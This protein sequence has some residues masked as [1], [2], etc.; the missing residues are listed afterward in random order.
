MTEFI[1]PFGLDHFIYL[2]IFLIIAGLFF[3]KRNKVTENKN[4]ITK[5]ILLT[6]ILQQ[7]VLYGSYFILEDFDISV[8]LPLHISRINTIMGILY[9]ITKDKD[10]YKVISFTGFFALLSFL[11]PSQ[12]H[13]ISHPIGISFLVNHIITLLLPFYARICYEEEYPWDDKNFAFGFFLTYLLSVYTLNPLIDGNYF[14]L[15]NRPI[16]A[17]NGIPDLIYLVLCTVF[18][19]GL[20]TIV[21][22]LYKYLEE[23][24]LFEKLNTKKLTQLI[25]TK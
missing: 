16:S 25:I 12:V 1:K 19:F 18:A 24:P 8:S 7:I 10:I 14:Y 22:L 23:R 13:K 15:V 3:V 20:F 4:T 6:S 17:L 5:I 9:L 2:T 21:E 11:Y